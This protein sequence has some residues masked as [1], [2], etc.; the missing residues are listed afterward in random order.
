[1]CGK[2]KIVWIIKQRWKNM[3]RERGKTDNKQVRAHKHTIFVG[4]HCAKKET[5]LGHSRIRSKYNIKNLPSRNELCRISLALRLQD[6]LQP[7]YAAALLIVWLVALCE[8]ATGEVATGEVNSTPFLVS[9]CHV[10]LFL[11][12]I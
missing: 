1:M 4:K 12:S 2:C 7:T 10:I 11:I 5:P 3:V 8:V 6:F 9:K